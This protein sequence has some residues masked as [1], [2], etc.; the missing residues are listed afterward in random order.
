MT[1]AE[2]VDPVLTAKQALM[3]ALGEKWPL[4]LANMKLWF[5]KKSTKE[6]FDLECRRLFSADQMHLHNRFLLAMLNKIDAVSPP[7]SVQGYSGD[8]KSSSGGKSGSG[9]SSKKRKRS[10]KTSSDRSTFEPVSVHEYIPKELVDYEQMANQSAAVPTIRYASQ[11][12]FLPDNGLVLG[13]LLVGAWENGLTNVDD[14]AVDMV[15]QSVQ[16]LLKNILTAIILRRKHY[17]TS[18]NGTFLYDVGHQ[19]P[20]PFV[21]NT[22]T[23]QKVDDEPMELDKEITTV[24]YLK[25][26]AGESQFLASCGEPYPNQKRKITVYDVYKTLLNRNVISSHSVYSMNME[27]ISSLLS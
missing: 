23:K 10:S 1:T 2:S 7:A 4:Y 9:S 13:R 17:R 3:L 12:L 19:L 20:H 14:S 8:G 15:V 5:R 25:P 18:S 26:A 24:C 27:R 11:E 6:E 21:R 22:V 16:V